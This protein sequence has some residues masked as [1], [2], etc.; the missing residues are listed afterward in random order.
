MVTPSEH[1]G[2]PGQYIVRF[3]DD[4][5]DPEKIAR[6][7]VHNS[8]LLYVYSHAIK[9]FAARLPRQAAEAIS[10]RADVEYVAQDEELT[11]EMIS[12][13]A[14]VPSAWAL[15][16]VSNRTRVL[17]EPFEYL[18]SGSNV[19]VYVVDSGIRG[20]HQEFSG[21]T[22][23]GWTYTTDHPAWSD[24]TGHGTMV[25]SAAVGSTTGVALN[26]RL[27]SVRVFG[28]QWTT[29][30]SRINA[31]LDWI[32]ANHVKPAIVNLSL[33][34]EVDWWNPA[35]WITTD[36]AV[37]A[38]IDDGVTV[39]VAAGNSGENACGYA[40]ARVPEAITVAASDY[41]DYPSVWTSGSTNYGECVDL[42]GPGSAVRAATL[43]GNSTY[44]NGFAGTSAAAPYVAGTAAAMLS[45]ESTATPDRVHSILT[46]SSTKNSIQNVSLTP[47]QLL[48]SPF[49]TSS[50][51][52]PGTVIT[53][54]TYQWS[55]RTSGGNGSQ[56]YTWHRSDNGGQWYAV[57]TTS[58]YSGYI[59]DTAPS[60][61]L[62]L[63][64]N[65]GIS[66]EVSSDHQVTYDPPDCG[67]T[68]C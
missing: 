23:Q 4:V 19:N 9:G 15:S 56:S 49:T 41:N 40:P 17:S 57:S 63:T 24:C 46:L 64:I 20:T 21:R 61:R 3:R 6:G 29:Y 67:R 51:S 11:L 36:D 16:R 55:A 45:A 1:G 35:S 8:D 62:R 68:R 58:T 13:S 66:S 38:L 47:N 59:G 54:G 5:E 26:A 53:A 65:Y 43:S 30:S 42:F 34:K 39:V 32:K 10:K 14:S 22:G 37:Q 52:G 25:A 60:F 12:H 31:G 33:G 27:H 7:L 50:I 18:H 28:C 44:T 48:Y 2:V